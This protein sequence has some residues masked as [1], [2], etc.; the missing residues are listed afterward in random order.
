V[1]LPAIF[2][3][4]Y[5]PVARQARPVSELTAPLAPHGA[6]ELWRRL[7]HRSSLAYQPFPQRPAQPGR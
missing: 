7:G 5:D 6:E 2:G 1:D 3:S 4:W